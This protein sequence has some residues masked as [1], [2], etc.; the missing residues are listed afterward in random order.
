M[1]FLSLFLVG[2]VVSGL[3]LLLAIG[4]FG[5]R[6]FGLR[7]FLEGVIFNKDWGNFACAFRFIEKL[8]VSYNSLSNYFLGRR[9]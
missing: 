7:K 1:G 5:E 9:P 2:L 4:L 8:L 3:E 6:C